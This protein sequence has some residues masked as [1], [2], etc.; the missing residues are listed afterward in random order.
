MKNETKPKQKKT[1]T[2]TLSYTSYF[3]ISH[4]IYHMSSH[5]CHISE[6]LDYLDRGKRKFNHYC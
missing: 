5:I 4:I 3:I 6:F 2:N 1:E